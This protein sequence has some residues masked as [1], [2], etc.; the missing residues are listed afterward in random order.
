MGTRDWDESSNPGVDLHVWESTWASIEEEADGDPSAALSQYSDL[1]ER[2]LG[3]QGY[4][5]DD[6]VVSQGE[7]PE[8]VVT[9]RS[10]RETNERAELGAASRSEVEL[11]IED[12]RSVFG[13]FVSESRS[14]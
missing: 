2:M 12:L 3:A 11:A 5:L 6:P 8:I 10:A 1:V 4:G 13:S 14:A 7:A 9:Y